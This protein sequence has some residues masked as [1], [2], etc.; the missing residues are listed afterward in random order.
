MYKNSFRLVVLDSSTLG[1]RYEMIY[2][3]SVALAKVT[4]NFFFLTRNLP[5]FFFC[6]ANFLR[7]N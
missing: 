6:L 5:R 4:A 2:Q 1:Q 7:E 3:F